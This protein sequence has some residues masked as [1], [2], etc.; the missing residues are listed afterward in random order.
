MATTLATMAAPV[1]FDFQNNNV[2]VMTLD[3]L[4]RTHKENDIYGNPVKGIYHYEV[5]ERM[6]DICKKYNLN[7]EVEEIFA[8]QNKNKAQP[9]VVVLPQVE[10]KYGENAVEAHVLRRVYATIRIKNWETD[11]LTTT[12]VVAF[13]QDGIQA[14]IGPCVL[15]CHNQCILS[16]ERSVSNYGKEKVSTE[17]LFDRVDGWLSNFEEQMNEDRERIRRLKEKTITPVEM[18]A[19]IGLLTALRVSHDSSDKRLSSTV[20]TYPLNQSQISIFTEDLLKLSQEKQTL[21]AWDVYNCATELYKPGKTDLPA[22]IPQNGALA[23][24]MLAES[25][26]NA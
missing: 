19:Y 13:H 3:T 5:I 26:P 2:E 4:R 15:V 17:E 24:M 9:G 6:T 23:E 14:A 22:M 20:E 21:T 1:Q 12:L 16:P 8:A 11:E 25:L 18:Y 10:E 7:Y